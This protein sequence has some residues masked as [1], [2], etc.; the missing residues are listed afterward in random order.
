MAYVVEVD[1]SGRKVEN[2]SKATVVAFANGK[3]RAIL[4]PAEVKREIIPKLRQHTRADSL[5]YLLFATVLY[6][7]LKDDIEQID[8]AIIDIEYR[9]KEDRIKAHLINLLRRAG[10][11]VENSQIQFDW[12]TKKSP[13][14]RTAIRTFR[15]QRE[16]DH[17]VSLD[18][19][20]REF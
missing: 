7:L 12:I 14:H 3:E 2:T 8:R 9:G 15:G 19:L 11:R 13:A 6:L 20:L 18:E 10:K 1:Q 5:H 17:V 4:V 16:P